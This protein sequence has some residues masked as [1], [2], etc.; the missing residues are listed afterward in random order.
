[1]FVKAPS[2]SFPSAL[3]HI[4]PAFPWSNKAIWT[5]EIHLKGLVLHLVGIQGVFI[6]YCVV[7]TMLKAGRN[8][9]SLCR[10]V[11]GCINCLFPFSLQS[12]PPVS[13][14]PFLTDSPKSHYNICWPLFLV[15]QFRDREVRKVGVC[16]QYP[17][18]TTFQLGEGG[19]SGCRQEELRTVHLQGKDETASI[20]CLQPIS[21]TKWFS[22]KSSPNCNEYFNARENFIPVVAGV[23]FYLLVEWWAVVPEPHCW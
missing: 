9:S 7:L 10:S 3:Q 6:C 18:E 5:G 23:T 1:M 11:A 15:L 12:L 21:N 8:E 20:T 2:K 22:A 14:F 16:H 17:S 19:G 13:G 4:S